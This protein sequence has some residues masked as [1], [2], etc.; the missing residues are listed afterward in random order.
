MLLALAEDPKASMA[1]SPYLMASLAAKRREWYHA[2]VLA[3]LPDSMPQ[4]IKQTHASRVVHAWGSTADNYLADLNEF[5]TWH[6]AADIAFPIDGVFT[7]GTQTMFVE[8]LLS[9]TK[10]GRG[11]HL[12]IS[13]ITNKL[14]AVKTC[15]ERVGIEF[16]NWPVTTLHVLKNELAQRQKLGLEVKYHKLPILPRVIMELEEY[17]LTCPYAAHHSLHIFAAVAVYLAFYFAWRDSTLSALRFA[18]ISFQHEGRIAV[19]A[20]SFTK[21]A[22]GKASHFFR[23]LEIDL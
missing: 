21:G 2:A 17:L 9:R 3:S 18:D 23:R 7:I 1:P 15:L 11:S 8:H 22:F 10:G 14:S 13:T 16:G 20:E 5:V 19:F 4:D 12:K 6:R